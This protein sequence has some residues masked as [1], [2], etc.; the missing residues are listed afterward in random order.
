MDKG[1]IL[2]GHGSGGSLMHELIGRMLAPRFSN[3]ILNELADGARL[4]LREKLAFS[5]D[6]FV[7]SPLFVPGADIG[8]LAVCGTANDLVMMGARP[9]YLALSLIVEE[10]LEEAVL[11]RAVLS[12][13][14]EAKINGIQVV[15]GDLKVVEKG[16]ADKLFINT[17]GVG[18][19]LKGRALS[20]QRIRPGD[21]VILTSDIGR[22]G[23]AVL[24]KRKELSPGFNIKSDCRCLAGMLLPVVKDF[25]SLKFMRDPTRGGVATTLNEAARTS[26]LGFLIE[27]EKV[28][29]CAR[30]RSA[31]ELLGLDALYAANEGAAVLV[32]GRESA[33]KIVA[34]LKRH[35]FGGSAAVIGEVTGAN[36]GKVVLKTRLG[37]ERIVDMLAGEALPRIC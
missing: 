4:P 13:S 18:R 24:A 35:P 33:A 14:R 29:V 9:E 36:R 2:L 32:C 7:V 19:L 17:A 34:R 37:G 3:P 5:A 22:H 16:A 12:A 20:S 31:C 15:T 25:P 6:S 10:G 8:K 11:E 21:K 26:A 23:L 1:R 30:V 28:P 27:E